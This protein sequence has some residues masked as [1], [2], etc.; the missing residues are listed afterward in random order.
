MWLELRRVL[1]RS[2]NGKKRIA[3]GIQGEAA[4]ITVNNQSADIHTK[5]QNGDK[6]IVQPSTTGET[7]SPILGNIPELNEGFCVYID[8][9]K[10][11]LPKTA[12]VNKKLEIETYHIKDGDVIEVKNW[13]SVSQIVELADIPINPNT[14]IIV[15]D[16]IAKLTTKVYDQDI[17]SLKEKEL[18][19]SQN[20]KPKK[21]K[22]KTL[23]VIEV[24]INGKLVKLT[25]KKEYIFVDVFDF[26]DFNLNDA[27]GRA[28]VT[29]L[30]GKTAEYMETIKDRDVIDIY[31]RN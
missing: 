31:W 27:N 22:N 26:I 13:Y 17:F 18:E 10:V 7:A 16:V 5:I 20:L 4:I 8:G 23:D 3:R 19:A 28:I 25:G 29:E 2:V 6:I 11:M 9:M 21:T 30:N 1:F 14:E 12:N 24:M 15:N